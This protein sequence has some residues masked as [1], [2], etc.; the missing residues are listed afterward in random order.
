[1]TSLSLCRLIAFNIIKDV[2]QTTYL[3]RYNVRRN[4]Q[5]WSS[6]VTNEGK[7]HSNNNKNNDNNEINKNALRKK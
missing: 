5:N 6:H 4:Y 2:S 7:K 3:E 1:M